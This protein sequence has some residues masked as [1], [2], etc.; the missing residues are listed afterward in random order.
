MTGHALEREAALLADLHSAGTAF[1]V[2]EHEATATVA[3]SAAVKDHIAGAHTKNLFL[4][5][6]RGRFWLV[7]M[8]AEERADLKFMASRL[9]APR[10]SFGK[11]E[12]M[13]AFLGVVPG[14]VTPLAAFNDT[15]GRVQVVLDA[16]FAP[17]GTINI[18]PLR[19]TATLSMQAA[20]LVAALTRWNHAPQV[21]TLKPD[22][23]SR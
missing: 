16:A 19:N 7:T 2:F 6:R 13:V 23:A 10:L 9:G 3:E 12:D 8:P 15:E 5:D 14:S 17:D 1:R 21:L 20:D 18:H 22:Q 4:T 11:A